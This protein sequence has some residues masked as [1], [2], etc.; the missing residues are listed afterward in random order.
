MTRAHIG[1]RAESKPLEERIALTPNVARK[2]L[3]AGFKITVAIAIES[4][5]AGEL[6]IGISPAPHDEKIVTKWLNELDK[7]NEKVFRH[8]LV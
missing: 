5:V 7:M 4:L 3:Q 8:R 2:L 1:L 6:A